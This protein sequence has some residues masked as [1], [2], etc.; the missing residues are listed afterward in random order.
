LTLKD[1]HGCETPTTHGDVGEL[2]R[3]SVRS[4]SEQMRTSDIHATKDEC[5]TNMALVS[6]EHLFEHGHGGYHPGLPA[7][8]EGVEFDVGRDEGC[9]EFGICGC[10]STT[11][12]NVLRDVMNL[13]LVI[14]KEWMERLS[15]AHLFAVLVCYD[16]TLS[17]SRVGSKDDAIFV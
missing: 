3:A 15:S 2:V 13:E 16:R 1:S 14:C 6:E 5:G 11:A 7:G 8:R 9:R 12:A 4:D 17:S 10:T